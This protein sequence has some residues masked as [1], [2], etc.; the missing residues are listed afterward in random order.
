MRNGNTEV[1]TNQPIYHDGKWKVWHV[2]GSNHE[3]Y[4]VHGYAESEDGRSGW[5]KHEVFAPPEMKMFDFCVRKR[6][7]AFD[8]IFARVWVRG[9]TQ[10][11]KQDSGG[12]ELE[13]HQVVFQLE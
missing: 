7:E 2:A 6:G 11:R 13:H 4:L 3:D 5:T 9:G 1:S 8:A 12:A 10:R